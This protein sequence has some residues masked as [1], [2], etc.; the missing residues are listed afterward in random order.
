MTIA[1]PNE[2][3]QPL[4]SGDE[5][6]NPDAPIGQHRPPSAV[7]PPGRAIADVDDI[8]DSLASLGTAATG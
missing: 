6:V 2:R 3:D 1:G 8:A 4:G 5:V 7:R